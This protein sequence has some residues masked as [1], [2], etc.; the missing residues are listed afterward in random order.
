MLKPLQGIIEFCS[1]ETHPQVLIVGSQCLARLD[2]NTLRTGEWI[3]Q[4]TD[5]RHIHFDQCRRTGRRAMPF[6]Q[7]S[8]AFEES[9]GD[10]QIIF[11]GL[12]TRPS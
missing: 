10:V 12:E 7:L 8:P 5:R 3:N 6:K 4:V 11:D 1:S 2:Q 9:V